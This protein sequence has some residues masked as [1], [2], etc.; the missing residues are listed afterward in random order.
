MSCIIHGPNAS[1]RHRNNYGF[2]A[3]PNLGPRAAINLRRSINRRWTYPAWLSGVVREVGAP[4]AVKSF[5]RSVRR[6]LLTQVKV[7]GSEWGIFRNH[8]RS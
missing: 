4:G 7:K 1:P 5:A 8:F 3:A 6:P 2:L